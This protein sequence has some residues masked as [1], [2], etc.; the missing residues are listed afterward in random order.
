MI[1]TD[2]ITTVVAQRAYW[3]LESVAMV[4]FKRCLENSVNHPRIALLLNIN[5]ATA[6][7]SPLVVVMGILMQVKSVTKELLTPLLQMLLA[8]QTVH[9]LAV[10]TVS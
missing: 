4:A 2:E 1:E 6:D 8:A 5:V 7:S 3:R 9:S 10:V